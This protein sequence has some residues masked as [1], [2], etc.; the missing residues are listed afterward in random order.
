MSFLFRLS[1]A[2][3]VFMQCNIIC[4]FVRIAQVRVLLKRHYALLISACTNLLRFVL[5]CRLFLHTHRIRNFHAHYLSFIATAQAFREGVRPCLVINKLD[6]LHTELKLTPLEV[7]HHLRE[8]LQTV[9]A[10][11]VCLSICLFC[12]LFLVN[13]CVCNTT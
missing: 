11:M 7:Y 10:F 9:N 2:Q 5:F 12:I 3:R 8:L 13:V 4:P 1:C 6:R